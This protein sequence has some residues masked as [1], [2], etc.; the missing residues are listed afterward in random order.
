MENLS[1]VNNIVSW[2]YRLSMAEER[3]NNLSGLPVEEA[4]LAQDSQKFE[5]RSSRK[6]IIYRRNMKPASQCC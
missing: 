2:D 5:A 3:K 1:L 4:E 6:Q